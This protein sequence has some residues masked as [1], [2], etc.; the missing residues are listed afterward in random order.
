[1]CACVI[2]IPLCWFKSFKYLSYV[3]LFSNSSIVFGL[4]VIFIYAGRTIREKPYLHEADDFHYF[5][6]T[7]IPMFF[8]VAVFNFEGNATL[9]AI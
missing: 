5:R 2:L 7:Q 6:V 1:M 9:M 4:I 8:G 3:S